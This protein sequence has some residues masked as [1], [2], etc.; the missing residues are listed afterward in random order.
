[1]HAEGERQRKHGES[2]G[3]NTE[4]EVKYV[5]VNQTKK[6]K[7]TKENIDKQNNINRKKIKAR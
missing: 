1:M 3:R 7:M 4:E 2:N 5:T 6:N